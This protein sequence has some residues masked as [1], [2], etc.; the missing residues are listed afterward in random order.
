MAEPF[1]PFLVEPDGMI[2]DS[3]FSRLRPHLKLPGVRRQQLL[4]LDLNL[5]F[6]TS[7]CGDV[8]LIRT[9]E[10]F[11][12]IVDKSKFPGGYEAQQ[13]SS[14]AEA[15][16]STTVAARLFIVHRSAW[17]A[18][19]LDPVSKSNW[20]GQVM[21]LTQNRFAAG[22]EC[23][24][25]N[26]GMKPSNQLMLQSSPAANLFWYLCLQ[27]LGPLLPKHLCAQ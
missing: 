17:A 20:L 3:L 15:A 6:R 2:A 14:G 7:L 18:W 25:C 23:S 10:Q 4:R 24:K 21:L 27:G 13:P 5:P 22:H 12:Q 16:S 11:C 8:A 19:D 9:R 1:E 26:L